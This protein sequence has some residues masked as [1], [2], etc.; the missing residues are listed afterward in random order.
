MVRV[1]NMDIQMAEGFWFGMNK[2]HIPNVKMYLMSIRDGEFTRNQ[3]P[4]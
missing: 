4:V 1:M 3:I 2:D